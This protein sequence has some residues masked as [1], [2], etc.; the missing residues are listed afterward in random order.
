MLQSMPYGTM[1]ARRTECRGTGTGVCGA[2]LPTVASRNLLRMAA[3]GSAAHSDHARDMAFTLLAAAN[4]ET[5]D[6][7]ITDVKKLY[8]IAGNPGDRV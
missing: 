4:G 3:A 8:R 5:K 1:P 7:K 6:F 2:T